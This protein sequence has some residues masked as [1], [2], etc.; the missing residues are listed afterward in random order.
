M[1]WNNLFGKK[2]WAIAATFPKNAIYSVLELVVWQEGF[3]HCLNMVENTIIYSVLKQFVW[4]EG[5]N[6]C[7]NMTRKHCNLQCFEA[8]GMRIFCEQS[9]ENTVFFSV[10]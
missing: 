2:A 4:Q 6:H 10:F 8:V 5:L 1:F 3:N 7:F 9:E